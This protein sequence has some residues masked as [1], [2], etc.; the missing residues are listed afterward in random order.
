[1]KSIVLASLLSVVLCADP[2]PKT[3]AVYCN[4][5]NDICGV[6][7]RSMCCGSSTNGVVVLEDGTETTTKVP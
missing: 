7:D 4:S 5:P 1:M 6:S 3:L 2:D